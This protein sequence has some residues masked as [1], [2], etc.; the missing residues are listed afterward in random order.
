MVV[1]L[2]VAGGTAGWALASGSG[3]S[4][5]TTRL[6]AASLG[7]I[8]QTATATGTIE[9]TNQA[10]LS[11]AVAGQVTSVQATVGA[12]VTAGQTLATIDSAALATQAAQAQAAVAG[13]E[14]KVA[15]DGSSGV[16]STQLSAD[17]AA[18][19]S[20]RD[21]ASTAAKNLAASAMTSP[22]A[23]TVAAVNL[24]VGQNLAGGSASGGG[25]G[26]GSGSAAGSG[27]GT[28]TGGGGTGGGASASSASSASSSLTTS[29]SSA[30]NAQIVV[31]G[32]DS[33]LVNATVD[34]STVGQLKTGDQAIVTLAGSSATGRSTGAG[35]SAGA[36]SVAAGGSGGTGRTGGTGGAA[37]I[38]GTVGTIG[39]IATTSSGVAS[40][41]VTINITGSPSGLHPGASADVSIIVRQ[42]SN[43][44]TIPTQ[45]LHTSG[46]QTIVYESR[47]GH[48]VSK[49]VTTGVT[50]GA[51]TQI[52][53]GL[54][55]GEQVVVPVT[56]GGG[57]ARARTTG[58]A[59][60]RGG[61]GGGGFGGGGFGAGGAGFGGRS[62]G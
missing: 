16:S 31:V 28:G 40:Y 37:P 46:A 36:T 11:F 8:R 33:Y 54:T 15:S 53:S 6:V 7:Q 59:A 1:I 57:T 10:N 35:G 50:S 21:S 55:A 22:I 2:A 45:A 32:T 25:S 30:A 29:T 20:A 13:D 3:S 58:G 62:A 23:G 47:G 5:P 4:S 41:P 27:S 52:V 18:L 9:P 24:A 61:F 44:L 17:E 26:T 34:D 12:A 39:L 43:I 56:A 42:L 19:T 38:Y 49:A 48:Q 14:V 60:T 51:Q